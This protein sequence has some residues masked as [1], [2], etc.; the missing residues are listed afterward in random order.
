MTSTAD[1]RRKFIEFGTAFAGKAVLTAA[2]RAAGADRQL[3]SRLERL[4]P[5]ERPACI[6]CSLHE[7]EYKLQIFLSLAPR[8]YRTV[9]DVPSEEYARDL[10]MKY[11]IAKDFAVTYWKHIL[12]ENPDIAKALTAARPDL[13][14]ELRV[15]PDSKTTLYFDSACEWRVGLFCVWVD[16]DGRPV[17]KSDS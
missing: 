2:L 11:H 15:D 3:N 12:L 9:V 16:A 6:T 14:W 1:E 13:D 8:E 7:T 5:T 17:M 4:M 10:Y